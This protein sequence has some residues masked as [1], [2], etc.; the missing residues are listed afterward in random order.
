MAEGGEKMRGQVDGG[1][2]ALLDLFVQEL[3]RSVEQV[4]VNQEA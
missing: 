1:W 3:A 2:P 4:P